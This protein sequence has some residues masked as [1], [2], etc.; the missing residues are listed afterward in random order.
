M[1]KQSSEDFNITNLLK[2]ESVLFKKKRREFKKVCSAILGEFN[3]KNGQTIKLA[4]SYC[5]IKK[6]KK[7]LI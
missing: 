6:N 2:L 7:K 1:A 3:D 4:S 5:E